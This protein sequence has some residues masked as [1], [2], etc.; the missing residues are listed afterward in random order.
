MVR[1]I[2]NQAEQD[3]VLHLP[4]EM[5]GKTIEVIAFEIQDNKSK[6]SKEERLFEIEKLTQ[7]SSRDLSGFKF[8]RDEA[9]NYDE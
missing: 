4:K 3:V 8:N 5:V 2:I 9:N 7:K 1:E 6:L